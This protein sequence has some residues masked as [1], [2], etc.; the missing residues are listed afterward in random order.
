MS[1]GWERWFYHYDALFW[2]TLERA[3]VTDYGSLSI[4]GTDEINRNFFICTHLPLQDVEFS[5]DPLGGLISS[6]FHS[7]SLLH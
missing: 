5:V 3:G 1:I 6:T 4:G 7:H 2:W